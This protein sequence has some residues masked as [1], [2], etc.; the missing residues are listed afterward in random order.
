MTDNIE[1]E[2]VEV[3]TKVFQI[4][5][6]E[7][8]SIKFQQSNQWDSFKHIELL[9]EIEDKFLVQFEDFETPTISDFASAC[10]FVRAQKESD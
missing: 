4:K 5:K 3:F 7:I 10:M 1:A 8:N 6:S 9:L 2:M